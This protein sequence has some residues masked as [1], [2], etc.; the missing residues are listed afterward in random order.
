MSKNIFDHVSASEHS[1]LHYLAHFNKFQT[2]ESVGED[3][4]FFFNSEMFGHAINTEI[5]LDGEEVWFL[6]FPVIDVVK[7]STQIHAGLKDN[8]QN[9]ENQKGLQRFTSDQKL[10]SA[11]LKY[12]IESLTARYK[13][14]KSENLTVVINELAAWADENCPNFK[15]KT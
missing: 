13:K 1:A 2:L 4:A 10:L 7:V 5:E 15:S 8:W 11:L 3:A 12:M 14:E 9:S 6:K